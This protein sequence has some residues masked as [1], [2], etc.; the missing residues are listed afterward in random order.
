MI[1][2]CDRIRQRPNT[3]L[4]LA[5]AELSGSEDLVVGILLV[6][7]SESRFDESQRHVR[8]V[9]DDPSYEPSVAIPLLAFDTN[10]LPEDEIGRELLRPLGEIRAGLWTIDR[11]QPNSCLLAAIV[12]G[13]RVS[14]RDA[15]DLGVEGLR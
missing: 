7:P 1:P 10:L 15:D 12:D 13:D 3:D 11:I 4:L 9:H 5:S 8:P 6:V 14:V 2:R